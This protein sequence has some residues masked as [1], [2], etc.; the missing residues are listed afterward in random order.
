M[1]LTHEPVTV[2]LPSMLHE[3]RY[4][5]ITKQSRPQGHRAPF[6]G[7]IMSPAFERTLSK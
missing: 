4:V 7:N 2:G 1:I 6:L 5:N 3:E